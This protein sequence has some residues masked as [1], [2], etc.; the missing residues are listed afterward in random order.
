MKESL[1]NSGLCLHDELN[2]TK[3]NFFYLDLAC[4]LYLVYA[5]SKCSLDEH[6]IYDTFLCGVTVLSPRVMSCNVWKCP[7]RGMFVV[8]W[9]KLLPD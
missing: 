2:K 5:N 7:N 6:F 9:S 4:M 1:L 3:N 8:K